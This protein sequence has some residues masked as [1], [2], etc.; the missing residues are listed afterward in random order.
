MNRLPLLVSIVVLSAAASCGPK[1]KPADPGGGAG[2][3]T[4]APAPTSWVEM[5]H[6][7]RIDFM[8]NSVVPTMAPLFPRA[9]GGGAP[10][11]A[12]IIRPRCSSPKSMRFLSWFISTQL[13]PRHQHRRGSAGPG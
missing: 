2:A 7:Q 4:D 11:T 12:S 13:A 1:S 3:G 6:E 8:K 9:A 10:G 5:N